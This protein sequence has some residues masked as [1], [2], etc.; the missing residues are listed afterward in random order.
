MNMAQAVAVDAQVLEVVQ[1]FYGA[2]LD[3]SGWPTALGALVDL[4]ASQ[5]ATLWML[6]GSG[7]PRFPLFTYIN[8][9]PASIE[10]YLGRFAAI[11][12][13]VQYLVRHPSQPIVHDALVISER[14]KDRH[15]YY[16]WHARHSDTRF[17][18]VG[19]VSLAPG[20]QAGVALHRTGR[21]GPYDPSA[22]EQFAFLHRHLEQ[23]LAVAFRLGSQGAL[24]QWSMA[25]LERS[26]V[27]V[28]LLDGRGRIIYV[29]RSAEVLHAA[30]DGVRFSDR[31]IMLLHR[32]DHQ[33]LQALIARALSAESAAGGAGVMRAIRPSGKRPFG[34]LV[35]RVAE[36]GPA[37]S[38]VRP[39]V[40]LF[41][42]DPAADVAVGDDRLQAAFGLT[43]AEA[44]LA[45]RLASGQD[46]RSAADQLGI[47]YGTA[48]VRLA[49]V[50]Q[51]TGTCRQGELI[52]L[53]LSTLQACPAPPGP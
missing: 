26:S 18:L 3:E 16:A 15:P 2:A 14:E 29:N 44:K 12:P 46:L 45:A 31:G 39:A 4:T 42:T 41:I 21:F 25:L 33:R 7:E 17:R 19:Q 6:D 53:L 32:R 48:R 36:W 22:V 51:K 23:A 35:N 20:V 1:A 5:A 40:F 43:G 8:F 10:E 37:L 13:T 9:D 24:Q 27:A 50:F 34:I 11:D 30:A 52:R 49:Q 28:V 47:T 38:T